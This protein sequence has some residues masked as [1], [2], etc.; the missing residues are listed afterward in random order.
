MQDYKPLGSTA[1]TTVKQAVLDHEDNINA[2]RSSNS[3][4]AFPTENLVVGMV[5]YRSDLKEMYQYNGTSW[6]KVPYTKEI[7]EAVS[8]KSLTVSGETSVPTPSVDNN[9]QTIANTQFVHGAI[10]KL[11][12]GAPAAL[13]TLQELSSALGDDPN[14]STTVLNKIAEKESKTDADIE[15][16][17]I[18]TEMATLAKKSE[19]PT[20]VSQLS[21]DS[22][23]LTKD[24]TIS[25]EKITIAP[26]ST[27]TNF[28]SKLSRPLVAIHRANRFA[29]LP[30]DQIIIEKTTDGGK[31]W[32]DAKVSDDGKRRFF[33][34]VEIGGIS[35]PQ[36][37]GKVNSLCG[38]RITFTAQKYDVPVGTAETEKYNYWNSNYL[39]VQ[40]RYCNIDSIW[41]FLTSNS[42]HI[43]CKVERATG[44]NST[45]WVTV[46]ST[47]KLNG[48]SGYNF[49]RFGESTF[50]GNSSQQTQHWNYRLTFMTVYANGSSPNPNFDTQIQKIYQIQGFGIN[51]WTISTPMMYNDHL[52]GIDIN[53]NANFPASVNAVTLKQGGKALD[54]IYTANT[55]D[56][57]NALLDKAESGTVVPNASDWY[58][59]KYASDG[60]ERVVKRPVSALATYIKSTIPA[61][62]TTANGYM[63]KEDKAK[64]DGIADGA[65]KVVI[66]T[67]FSGTSD[68]PVSAKALSTVFEAYSQ[69]LRTYTD[70]SIND[71]SEVV[72]NIS[73]T[74]DKVPNTYATID[75]LSQAKK[76]LQE[77]SNIL[78]DAD[79]DYVMKR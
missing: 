1:T 40:E 61:A 14:F 66:D 3:G 29:F 9:S 71:I 55:R 28:A 56:G 17:S 38:I 77:G 10:N 63:S 68:N 57:L 31:T 7:A 47:Q 13:D 23:Y 45:N 51:C 46:L 48:W 5:C 26:V 20:K 62:T 11:V 54:S 59:S 42:E 27:S 75:A 52:Y 18:R 50:G 34:G 16:Q 15:H 8:T 37:D 12:N 64:L 33:S 39:K 21:N 78:V 30:A 69:D 22:G 79:G 24:S 19:L 44:G 58:L 4:S 74:L 36:I 73:E 60:V 32:E 25:E 76:E 41:L 72:N 43:G 65:T 2:I 35:I 49:L 70:D 53:K 67:T 6:D